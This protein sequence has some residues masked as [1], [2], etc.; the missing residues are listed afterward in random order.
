M[1][2]TTFLKVLLM[3]TFGV[4]SAAETGKCPPTEKCE[5]SFFGCISGRHGNG[6]NCTINP[7]YLTST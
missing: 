2:S 1:F 4:S 6:K 3:L 5:V 7:G